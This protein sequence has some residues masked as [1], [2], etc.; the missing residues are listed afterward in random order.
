MSRRSYMASQPGDP[1]FNN[2]K[3]ILVEPSKLHADIVYAT[4]LDSSLLHTIRQQL[5]FDDLAKDV[6]GHIGSTHASYSTLQGSSQNYQ[7]FK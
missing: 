5:H 2:Q 3:Q 6:V 7:E 4:P 1:A